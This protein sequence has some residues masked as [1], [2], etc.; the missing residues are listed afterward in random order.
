MKKRDDF[1]SDAFKTKVVSKKRLNE[2]IH[3]VL[4]KKQTII[5]DMRFDESGNAKMKIIEIANRL[6][7]SRQAVDF[8]LDRI[9]KK[10][11]VL[12]KQLNIKV[13]T[14]KPNKKN[15]R[16][17]SDTIT[18]SSHAA[19]LIESIEIL[20][21][22]P[23]TKKLN[24]NVSERVFS[25]GADQR[26]YYDHLLACIKIIKIKQQN[27]EILTKLEEQ[28]L[29]DYNEIVKTLNKYSKKKRIVNHKKR[30]VYDSEVD[31]LKNK[32]V[33]FIEEINR[34]GKLPESKYNDIF[35]VGKK[36]IDGTDQ[37]NFYVALR[38]NSNNIR[39][40]YENGETLSNLDKEK[41]ISIKL[42][43][44]V[45]SFYPKKFFYN[46]LLIMDIAS[47]IGIDV[48]KNKIIF[49]KSFGEF[50]AKIRFLSDNG[51][52]IVDNNGNINSIMFMADLNMQA[53]YNVSLKELTDKYVNGLIDSKV[54][55]DVVKKIYR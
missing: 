50:Y 17:K 46:K 11:I 20:K 28:K 32:T 24:N 52:P 49:S 35:S 48:E 13:E 26:S 41:L 6:N 7:I 51:L 16:K 43:N 33:E 5:Y 21:R 34:T 37:R 29:Y 47:S 36:F 39:K 15:E 18:L 42:I 27:G 30:L 9:Y 40:K 38:Y 3:K 25:N 12:F 31:A 1:V 14:N 54:A 23:K 2:K 4:N 19:E 55:C 44:N 10:L 45:L 22:L 8:D 53:E